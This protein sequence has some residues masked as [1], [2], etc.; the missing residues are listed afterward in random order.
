MVP[1]LRTYLPRPPPSGRTLLAAYSY[2]QTG[3]R[4]W[5]ATTATTIGNVLRDRNS[6]PLSAIATWTEPGGHRH[7][8]LWGL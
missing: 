7:A 2:G 4:C 6:W 3:I 5:D 8:C 1:A